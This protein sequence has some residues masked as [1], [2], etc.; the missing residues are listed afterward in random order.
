[1]PT[2]WCTRWQVCCWRLWLWLP[3]CGGAVPV[4]PGMRRLQNGGL[5]PRGPLQVRRQVLHPKTV[6]TVVFPGWRC[7]SRLIRP[8][9]VPT[10]G[11]PGWMWTWMPC[12]ASLPGWSPA[13]WHPHRQGAA[14]SIPRGCSMSSNTP[15]SSCHWDSTVRRSRFCAR[16]LVSTVAEAR[17]YTSICCGSTRQW[18]VRRTTS[19][20]PRSSPPCLMWRCLPSMRLARVN[21]SWRTTPLP[22]PWSS[23]PG[24]SP[25][26]RTCWRD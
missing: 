16:T 4:R 3:T 26:S 13:R 8:S 25:T 14:G 12:P 6:A 22:W 19:N 20:W 11:M 15:I 7:W 10:A 24:M 21:A 23:L 5:A 18:G 9:V 17:R 2:P 1:M